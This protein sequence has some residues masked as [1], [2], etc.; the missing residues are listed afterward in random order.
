MH[1][2]GFMQ[3]V[4]PE[5]QQSQGHVMTDDRSVHLGVEPHLGPMTRF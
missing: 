4:M 5:G 1:E 2:I 3:S